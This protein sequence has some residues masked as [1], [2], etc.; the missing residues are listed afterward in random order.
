MTQN[1]FA[2]DIHISCKL[3]ILYCQSYKNLS[4]RIILKIWHNILKRL[5][6]FLI[7]FHKSLLKKKGKQKKILIKTRCDFS[8]WKNRSVQH[9]RIQRSIS[10]WIYRSKIC[11]ATFLVASFG[12]QLPPSPRYFLRATRINH[13]SQFFI[14]ME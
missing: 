7:Q 14:C 13:L 4:P 10:R 6:I 8:S 5:N 12:L 11:C 1:I 3:H 2:R 9:R